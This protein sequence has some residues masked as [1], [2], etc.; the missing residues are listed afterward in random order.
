[1]RHIGCTQP[2]CVRARRD[3]ARRRRVA[4][5]GLVD[6]DRRY[7]IDATP[8][9]AAQLDALNAGRTPEK[10]RPVDGILLTHAHVGHYAGLIALGREMLGAE[11]V[12]VY[13]TPKMASF[14]RGNEPWRSLV[15]RRN[16]NV[17]E[18]TPGHEIVLGRLRITVIAVPHR[19]ELSDTVGYRV[20]GPAGRGVLY[21]PDVDKWSAG[22]AAWITR[23]RRW[24]WRSSTAPSTTSELPG[25]E[26][27]QVPH[28]FV[29]ETLKALTPALRKRVR[30]IHLNHTNRLLWDAPARAAVAAQGAAIAREGDTIPLGPAD[31]RVRP[32]RPAP[33]P[34]PRRGGGSAATPDLPL[35]DVSGLEPLESALLGATADTLSLKQRLERL[36]A[37]AS[38]R[39][40]RRASLLPACVPLE[41]LLARAAGG[42]RAR[43]VLPRRGRRAPRDAARRRCRSRA[44][45]PSSGDGGGAGGRPVAGRL[46]PRGRAVFLDTETTGLAGGTGTAAFL[47]GV[48]LRGGR[49]L[50][51][52]PV[53]HARL[54]R[55]GRAPARPGRGAGR[56]SATS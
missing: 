5:L 31:G 40:Q 26:I 42:E 10:R 4:A 1:M 45:A 33:P 37:A 16:V 32:L 51:R 28:P 29:P 13:A 46:R 38:R 24:T 50:P 41:E 23:W 49:P 55:G 20:R 34:P 3:P 11:A 18:V 19:D 43:R 12:A 14:L 47:V 8:D 9:I 30:F 44:S 35:A 53:L 48:G 25:R 15:E 52:P 22:T 27:S 6:A 36:V 7:L 39:G 17:V 2:L 54:P 21:V 56:A